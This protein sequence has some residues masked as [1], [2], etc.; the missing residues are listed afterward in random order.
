MTPLHLTGHGHGL[1]TVGLVLSAHVF[2][3]YALS[4]VSG[5]LTDRLGSPVVIVAGLLL[6]GA[7][8]LL[9]AVFPPD[10]GII[11][12]VPLFLLGFGWSLGFV[13]GSA[14][15]TRG[16]TIRERTRLQ[17]WTDS[18]IWSSA[19][20]ASLTSGVIVAAASFA[21]LGLLGAAL[22][23]IPTWVV[24]RRRAALT[25]TRPAAAPGA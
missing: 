23:V 20:I 17:G 19:A 12:A 18:L 13:A 15:L 5:W 2:G 10:S 22:V 1:S 4:P 8:S 16:L 21:A 9:A 6:L 24:F 25:T 14:M 11:L 3:M 7:S